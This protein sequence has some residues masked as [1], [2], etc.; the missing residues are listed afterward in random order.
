MRSRHGRW[1]GRHPPTSLHSLY[2][3]PNVAEEGIVANFV[4]LTD[5]DDPQ[6]ELVVNLDLVAWMITHDARTRLVF[7]ASAGAERPDGRLSFIDVRESPT[8]I[9]G[10]GEGGNRASRGWARRSNADP[11]T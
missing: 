3:H 5:G 6:S 2:D 9:L 11:T 7:A 1:G 8:E 10:R 4:R